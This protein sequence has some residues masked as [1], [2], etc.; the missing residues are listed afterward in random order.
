MDSSSMKVPVLKVLFCVSS[1]MTVL[2]LSVSRVSVVIPIVAAP[3]NYPT[4]ARKF[5]GATTFSLTTLSLTPLCIT[6]K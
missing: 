1:S 5:K 3:Q 6:F 2:T 4:A